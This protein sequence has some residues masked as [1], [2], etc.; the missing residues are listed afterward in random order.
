MTTHQDPFADFDGVVRNTEEIR[1]HIGAPP[2]PV[3]TKVMVHI[4]PVSWALTEK[5]RFMSA[6]SRRRL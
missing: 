2:P 6:I 5:F 1:E 3:I 4:N